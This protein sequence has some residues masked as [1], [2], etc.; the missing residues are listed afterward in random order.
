MIDYERRVQKNEKYKDEFRGCLIGGAVGDALGYPVEFLKEK[1]IIARYG[2]NGIS[3]YELSENG[4]ALIS[5]DTQMTLFTATSLLLGMTRGMTRGVGGLHYSYAGFAYKTWYKMQMGEEP[6]DESDYAYS[7]LADVPEMG[8]HR[9]PGNTCMSVIGSGKYGTIDNPINDSKGCGG[10]MRI[11]PVGLYVN[12]PG[13]R[14]ANLDYLY[15]TASGVAALTHGH[16]LGWMSA[17]VL[18]HI[19]NLLTYSSDTLIEC[20]REAQ[21]YA[22]GLYG[23][24]RYFQKLNSLIDTAISLIPTDGNDFD[25]IQK[26]G[27]GWVAEETLAIAIY[28][29]LKY[30]DDFSKAICVA[31]N[32]DGDSDSTG[33]VTGNILGAL[34]GYEQIPDKWKENL[35]C[36]DVILEVADD[37]CH[38]CQIGEYGTFDRE[39]ERKYIENR[40][41]KHNK[42]NE[43]ANR[44]S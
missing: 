38:D 29:S 36:K 31:V 11:A 6:R 24:R 41:H 9:A 22:K 27:E 5:D 15:E 39:W 4:K 21:S 7:W 18:A 10:I 42:D 12:R 28:C 1:D 26:L 8:E 44:T 2:R 34:W 37:L 30:Q 3:E 33:S 17:A 35:E 25:N 23:E 43:T 14:N 13:G 40:W 16:E 20:I 32:H 19:I